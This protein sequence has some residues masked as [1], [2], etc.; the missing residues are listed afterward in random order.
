MLTTSFQSEGS[1]FMKPTEGKANKIPNKIGT[2]AVLLLWLCLHDLAL[3]SGKRH[4]FMCKAGTV[5][6]LVLS[7][8]LNALASQ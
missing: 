6:E 7:L 2:K 3:L 1:L 5:N 4:M 8:R